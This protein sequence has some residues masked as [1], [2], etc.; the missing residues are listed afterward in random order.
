MNCALVR[1]LGGALAAQLVAMTVVAYPASASDIEPQICRSLKALGYDESKELLTFSSKRRLCTMR[2]WTLF[3]P[4]PLEQILTA[5]ERTKYDQAIERNDCKRATDV[6]SDNFEAAHPD[7]PPHRADALSRSFWRNS[8]ATHYYES[9]GLCRDLRSV[10]QALK[11]IAEAGIEARPFWNMQE[12]Y[13]GAQTKFSIPVRNMYSGI[14]RLLNNLNRTRSHK[15][16]LA[17]LRLSDAGKAI[18]FHRHYELYMAIRLRNLGVNGPLI[19]EIIDRPIDADLR[20]RVEGMAKRK[21]SAG[22][23]MYPKT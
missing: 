18:K 10:R 21:D 3:Q 2:F 23:P 8:I 15:V 1:R 16:A 7:A 14:A 12:N 11:D 6:L 19:K 13:Y 20:A 9:L 5:T 17:L 4:R 22:I